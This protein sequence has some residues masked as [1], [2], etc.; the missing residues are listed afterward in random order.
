MGAKLIIAFGHKAEMGKDLAVQHII[1]QRNGKPYS[2]QR[3]G[4]ADA[5]KVECKD[6]AEELCGFYGVPYEAG[7]K[8]ARLLQCHG[9]AMRRKNPFYWV[10]KVKHLVEQAEVDIILI[11]D[12]RY[13]NE[14]FYVLST[15]GFA[16]KLEREG[17][18]STNRD[19]LHKSE[20]DLN[21]FDWTNHSSRRTGMIV[22]PLDSI[23]ELKQK[24]LEFYD[25]IVES[26]DY[27]TYF[28]TN[29]TPLDFGAEA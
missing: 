26:L 4:F 8:N 10:N 19:P 18:V 6:R 3:L 24:A 15:G 21:D 22:V 23:D 17:H 7:T 27:S 9:E 28:D 13:R 20:V 14:I 16:I 5:V 12:L 2:I 11:S 1:A 29:F 25:S